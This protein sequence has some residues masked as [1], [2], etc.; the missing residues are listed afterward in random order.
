MMFEFYADDARDGSLEEL[1]MN[2]LSPSD[3]A[4]AIVY[5][6]TDDSAQIT[7]ANLPVGLGVP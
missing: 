7:G 3:I 6:M 2:L 4:R 5:L 1:G